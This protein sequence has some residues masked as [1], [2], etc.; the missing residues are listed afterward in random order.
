M[1]QENLLWEE[2]GGRKDDFLGGI[3]ARGGGVP[4]H[5]SPNDRHTG[6]LLLL[7]LL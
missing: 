3:E 5:A 6:L 1:D 4:E 2:A 7:L